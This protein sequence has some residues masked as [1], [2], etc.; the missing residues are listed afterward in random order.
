VRDGA[1]IY[2]QKAPT[3]EQKKRFKFE[4][5]RLVEYQ[6]DIPVEKLKEYKSYRSFS[7]FEVRL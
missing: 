4:N 6:V 1:D 5:D 7:L 2:S 3:V